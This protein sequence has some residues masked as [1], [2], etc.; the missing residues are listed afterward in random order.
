MAAAAP[1]SAAERFR[2]AADQLAAVRRA[3]REN[4]KA[5]RSEAC[6]KQSQ[7]RQ[8]VLSAPASNTVLTIF[9]LAD[10]A[11]PAAHYLRA[12]AA[13]CGW[14]SK[15]NE[16]LEAYAV[17]HFV[18][19]DPAH[20]AAS[21]IEEDPVD[22]AAMRTA[23]RYLVEWRAVEWARDRVRGARVSP[24]S[25][26]FLQQYDGARLAVPEDVRPRCRGSASD[27]SAR[28]WMRRLRK[29]WGGRYGR[30]RVRDEPSMDVLQAK[31]PS[32]IFARTCVRACAAA[33]R[34]RGGSQATNVLSVLLFRRSGSVRGFT[35]GFR[36]WKF[37]RIPAAESRAESV[38]DCMENRSVWP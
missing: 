34:A 3:L 1:K 2:Q 21:S 23:Q 13:R 32:L 4:K 28:A 6:A 5:R 14:P 12:H 9:A 33:L 30:L 20:I 11:E 7:A 38:R 26:L 17:D 25:A 18:A 29:R 31:A 35:V 37:G 36:P 10:A 22:A 27:S 15:T 19:A 8:W 24:S 16:E